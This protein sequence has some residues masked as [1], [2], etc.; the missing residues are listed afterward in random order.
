MLKSTL[1]RG[2]LASSLFMAAAVGVAHADEGAKKWDA[3]SQTK[4]SLVQAIN[5]AEKHQTG[6]KAVQAE[7][8]VKRDKTYYEVE[9]VTPEK[10]VY[11]VKVDAQ[12]AAVISAEEDK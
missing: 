11:D 7:L 4:V 9:V 6:S 1:T 10:R 3:I 5:A 8:E 12:T 2:V